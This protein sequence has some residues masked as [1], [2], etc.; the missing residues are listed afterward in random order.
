MARFYRLLPAPGPQTGIFDREGMTAAAA[1]LL[2]RETLT[3]AQLG[4][5]LLVLFGVYL[6]NRPWSRSKVLN[7]G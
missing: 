4:G 1:W 3:A 5:G 2:L 7:P 6:T